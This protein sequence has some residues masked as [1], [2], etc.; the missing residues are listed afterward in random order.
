MN[1]V[2]LLSHNGEKVLRCNNAQVGDVIVH[3][4]KNYKLLELLPI[5]DGVSFFRIVEVV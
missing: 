3:K 1:K 5:F 4:N 2:L